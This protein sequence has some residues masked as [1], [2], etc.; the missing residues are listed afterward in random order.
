MTRTKANN[1]CL[2]FINEL[3]IYLW[4]LITCTYEQIRIAKDW[5]W[6]TYGKHPGRQHTKRTALS[7]Y[8]A[9]LI[10][11]FRLA[12]RS[13]FDYS[14][15]CLRRNWYVIYFVAGDGS[16]PRFI[17]FDRCS[18]CVCDGLITDISGIVSLWQTKSLTKWLINCGQFKVIVI[19]ASARL[20]STPQRTGR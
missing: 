19:T 4:I 12:R 2:R 15:N 8:A 7:G 9:N 6:G 17:E 14:D 13:D 11:R 1:C 16:P 3:F 10:Y 18:M 5:N 20:L